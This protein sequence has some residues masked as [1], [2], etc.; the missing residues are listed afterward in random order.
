VVQAGTSGPNGIW[1]VSLANPGS[2][3]AEVE[4]W[5]LDD[6]GLVGG[7]APQRVRIASGRTVILGAVLTQRAPLGAVIALATS[8]TVVAEATSF[9]TGGRG[10]AVAMGEPIPARWVPARLP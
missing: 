1:K 7:G 8:G 2:T 10:Y 6:R 3:P 4:V 5:L 9:V